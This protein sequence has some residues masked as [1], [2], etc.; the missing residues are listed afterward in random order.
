VVETNSTAVFIQ[1]SVKNYVSFVLEMITGLNVILMLIVTLFIGELSI[2]NYLFSTILYY[3][4]MHY[5]NVLIIDGYME[6]IVMKAKHRMIDEEVKNIASNK[7]ITML[8]EPSTIGDSNGI[9]IDFKDIVV[10]LCGK[11]VL[12]VHKLHIEKGSI[13]G[14]T[15]K[16][17]H[18][19]A[20]LLFKLV[21][22]TLGVIFIGNQ[23]ISLIGQD[24]LHSLISVVPYDLHAQDLTIG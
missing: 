11:R 16:G 7:Q 1:N 22:P 5:T 21:R 19:M 2:Y 17:S 10:N 12:E 9:S 24:N 6:I 20:T 14:I 13:V 15:G 23:D 3:L 4:I 18:L 8:Y